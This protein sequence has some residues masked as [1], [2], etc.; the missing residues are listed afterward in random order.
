MGLGQG[1]G[2]LPGISRSGITICTGTFVG[3]DRETTASFS[4]LMSIPIILASALLEGYSAIKGGIVV[5][6][7][8]LICGILSSA[9][10][11]YIA[12]K[13]M[14]RL[15]KKA[16]YKWFSLYIVLLII[17]LVIFECLGI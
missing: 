8:P 12:I 15:I 1:L 3:I 2:V 6:A 14:L 7:L 13:F 17:A 11:G 5:E 10:F 4:F 9:V 16:N